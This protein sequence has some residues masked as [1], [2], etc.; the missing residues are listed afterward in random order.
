MS[1]KW[2]YLSYSGSF[3]LVLF[4]FLFVT[5]ASL[6]WFFDSRAPL[7][8][9]NSPEC[10]NPAVPCSA[11][12]VSAVVDTSE[13]LAVFDAG[14]A[15]IGI[16]SN[17]PLGA[18][19]CRDQSNNLMSAS[20]SYPSSPKLTNF[21]FTCRKNPTLPGETI[22]LQVSVTDHAGNRRNASLSI[23]IAGRFVKL[24]D[25]SFHRA[26]SFDNDISNPVVAFPGSRDDGFRS[27]ITG[28]AGAY[29]AN[30]AADFGTAPVSQR[31]WSRTT[32]S[33]VHTINIS[34]FLEYIDARKEYVTKP[35]NLSSIDTSRINIINGSIAIDTV[36]KANVITNAAPTVIVVRNGNVTIGSAALT[37]FNTGDRSIAIIATGTGAGQGQIIAHTS[38][39][40][41]R[42]IF[43]GE[44]VN[45]ASS[46]TNNTLY[47]KGNIISQAGNDTSYRNRAG[48]NGN[49]PSIFV[50]FAPTMYMNLLPYLSTITYE[51]K[52]VQ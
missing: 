28:Q 24:M 41:M 26:T 11:V 10:P 4:L 18:G 2:K 6:G 9:I 13:M 50:E 30:G 31:G 49:Q 15:Q 21:R 20:N 32:Y 1:R 23:Q 33:P 46:G 48:S 39:T 3:L 47:I 19:E 42:G 14:I 36:A 25:T 7:I 17:I 38:L 43:I 44:S 22:T 29:T 35:T 51:W 37:T 5:R 8:T 52:Q 16:S 40:Q 45:F 34:D 27:F 12:S